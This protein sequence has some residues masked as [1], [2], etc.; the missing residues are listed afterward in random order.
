[1]K[2]ITTGAAIVSKVEIAPDGRP[3]SLPI[4]P[5]TVFSEPPKRAGNMRLPIDIR[6]ELGSVTP[7][8]SWDQEMGSELPETVSSILRNAPVSS[9]LLAN[10]PK[11]AAI[12]VSM[13]RATDCSG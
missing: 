10:P 1:M 12:D 4:A 13:P 9:D 5:V 6:D 2:L 8:A 3:D 11:S 7:E